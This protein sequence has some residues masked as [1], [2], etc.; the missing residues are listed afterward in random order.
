MK[1]DRDQRAKCTFSSSC[2]EGSGANPGALTYFQR[3][4]ESGSFYFCSVFSF[5]R[6]MVL[7][8]QEYS[9]H[10]YCIVQYCIFWYGV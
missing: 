1:I 9:E 5:M 10:K 2:I 7:P 8:D 6:M 4:R 3:G